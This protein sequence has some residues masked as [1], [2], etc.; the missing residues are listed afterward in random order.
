MT[1]AAEP[2]AHLTEL[3][4]SI[5]GEGPHVGA[6]QIFVR[7]YG[8]HRRCVFCD[9][10]ETVTAWQPPRFKPAT[11]RVEQTA[12][13]RD[14]VDAP[15]PWS[16]DRLFAA[17]LAYD[18]PRGTHHAVA[19][20]GGEPLL[21]ADYLRALLPRLREAGLACYLETAGDLYHELEKIL[22]WVDFCA[23]DLKLPSVTQNEAAWGSHRKFL[24]RCMAGGVEV[25][26]K[27]IVS[28][29]TSTADLDEAVAVVAD[30]AHDIP[31]IIQPMTPFGPAQNPP[32]ARQLIAWQD[33]AATRL[34]HV[35]VIPQCHKMMGQL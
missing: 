17:L 33:R 26:A 4:S 25:F 21:H 27:V 22:P 30:A 16:V 29:E 35:R 9:S 8:C 1:T 2:T 12:G 15:N 32:T 5:Q 3:F 18:Q 20:T 6:R 24:E 14:L 28:A 13:A 7:F 34:H 19:F 11:G 23:M 31:F 10:P